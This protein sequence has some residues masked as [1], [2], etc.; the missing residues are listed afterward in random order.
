MV[1]MCLCHTFNISNNAA[2]VSIL[3]DAYS[4]TAKDT[5]IKKMQPAS[6]A[7][8]AFNVRNMAHT[9]ARAGFV[10]TAP[11]SAFKVCDFVISKNWRTMLMRKEL[12]NKCKNHPFDG[13]SC[14]ISD[15]TPSKLRVYHFFKLLMHIC[16]TLLF[17]RCL[18]KY[19]CHIQVL[20]FWEKGSNFFVM[21]TLKHTNTFLYIN[22][23]FH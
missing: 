15:R 13:F 20:G 12:I 2:F 21:I 17:V 11:E 10:L 8:P 14:K 3:T 5:F 6:W 9:R 4:W 16:V 7:G 1:T 23:L 22:Y 18:Q 19:R